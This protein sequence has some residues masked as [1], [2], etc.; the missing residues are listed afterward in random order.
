[1]FKK[2]IKIIYKLIPLKKHLFSII[3]KFYVPSF[4]KYL[5]FNGVFELKI[6]EN[7][8]I[9]IYHNGLNVEN[10]LFWFGL[11]TKNWERETMKIWIKLSKISQVIFDIGAYTGIYSLLA[12]AINPNAKVFAFE[13]VIEIYKQLLKNIELNKFDITAVNKAISD[14]EGLATIKIPINPHEGDASLDLNEKIKHK[15]QTC[16]IINLKKFIEENKLE[17]VDLIKLDIEGSE[18]KALKGMG[19]YLEKF[20]PIIIIEILNED[21]AKEIIRLLPKNYVYFSINESVGIKM[22]ENIKSYFSIDNLN[23][24]YLLCEINLVNK[25]KIGL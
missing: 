10:E 24:N 12:K 23:R 21:I 9:K 16:N 20:R 13:P 4:Y 6:D 7:K 14:F 3:K 8:S 22:E 17:K 1:M 5:T 2:L 18:A 19:E 25:L 11:N 15:T